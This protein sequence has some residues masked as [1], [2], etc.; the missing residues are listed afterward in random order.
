LSTARTSSPTRRSSDLGGDEHLAA[1]VEATGGV[2]VEGVAFG[3]ADFPERFDDLAE[4]FVADDGVGV[5]GYVE[6]GGG[7]VAV[8]V[9]PPGDLDRKSTRLNSSHVKIS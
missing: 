5:L 8:N 6:G 1:A 7:V 9:F 3:V 4:G 2:P